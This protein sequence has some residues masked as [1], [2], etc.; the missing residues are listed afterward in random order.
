MK[1]REV[2]LRYLAFQIFNY[3]TDY[4]GDMSLFLEKAMKKINLI[5]DE[6]IE[7]L[8]KNFILVMKLTFQLFGDTNFRIPI[9]DKQGNN[10]RG[11]IN[12]AL[13]ESVAYFFSKHLH[14]LLQKPSLGNLLLIHYFHHI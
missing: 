13:L 4:E 6:E 12:T 5:S 1:D 8:K 14:T 9:I 10:K 2:V 11:R 7:K 3:E